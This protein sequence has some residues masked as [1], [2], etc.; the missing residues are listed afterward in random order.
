[1]VSLIIQPLLDCNQESNV[2]PVSSGMTLPSV[3]KEDRLPRHP[4]RWT[5]FR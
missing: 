5:I 4:Q 1:M 2:T 3:E